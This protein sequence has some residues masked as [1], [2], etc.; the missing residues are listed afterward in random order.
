M[1]TSIVV[2]GIAVFAWFYIWRQTVSVH[3]EKP[4]NWQERKSFP[5]YPV[6]ALPADKNIKMGGKFSRH[7]RA[8]Y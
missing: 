5:Q 6:K 1:Y 8:N 4:V 7:S 2:A 3:T